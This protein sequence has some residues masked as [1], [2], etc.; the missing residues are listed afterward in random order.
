ML[1]WSRRRLN[2]DPKRAA[3]AAGTRLGIYQQWEN[4]EKRPTIKQLYKV[5][6]FFKRPVSHFYLDEPPAEPEPRL[7]MRRVFGGTPVTDSFEFA[8][9]VQ[10]CTRRR[11]ITLDLYEVLGETAPAL[12]DPF[13]LHDDP[14]EIGRFARF[15][16][17]DIGP[18]TQTG[19]RSRYEA[20]R[21]WRNA[22]ED[23]GVL[24][25]QMSGV[26][27]DEARG[28]ALGTRPLPVAAFNSNDSV[29][30]RIFTLMHE[31]AHIL[32]G[33]SSLH[34]RSPME[35]DDDTERWCNRVAAAILIPKHHL[36]DLK[37]VR[38][39]GR[40][41]IWQARD[42]EEI[43]HRYWVSPSAVLRRLDTFER[44]AQHNF[45]ALREQFDARRPSPAE[46]SRGGGNFY[47]NQLAQL[48][49]LLPRLA[50]RSFYANQIS[51][52]DLSAI[53][54][55]KVDNLGTFEEKIMGSRYSF[56]DT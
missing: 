16:L 32:L 26:A 3:K 5:A 18:D 47:N 36:M 10:E 20:L 14:E 25:F 13:T 24:S 19:W 42:V 31:F 8:R 35:G 15:D 40:H 23:I 48:G 54:G 21:G 43:S 27:M 12:P 30:G 41:G 29:Q 37:R 53:M 45:E 56:P 52:G 55:T 33:A 22:L 1:A 9:Q 51:A 34:A 2:A 46:T 28:F 38:N 11:E 7:E 4:G 44:I 6:K 50:F 17:L 39:H 49:L